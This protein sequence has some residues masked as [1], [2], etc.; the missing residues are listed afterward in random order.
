LRPSLHPSPAHDDRSGQ[1]RLFVALNRDGGTVRRLGDDA[2]RERLAAGFARAGA[3][4]ELS[5]VRAAR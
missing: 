4:V 2:V 3:A 1:P 5:L